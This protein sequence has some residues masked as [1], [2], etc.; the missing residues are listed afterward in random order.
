VRIDEAFYLGGVEKTEIVKAF[1]ADIFFDDQ[2]VH[3][4]GTA[5]DVPS[6]KVPY[7]R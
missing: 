2:D 5:G 6:A 3:L 1:G 7:K 4:E